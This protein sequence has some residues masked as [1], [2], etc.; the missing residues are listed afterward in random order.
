MNVEDYPFTR[1]TKRR[2]G[3][4]T[5]LQG[6]AEAHQRGFQD[7]YKGVNRNPYPKGGRRAAY[8]QAYARCD[9]MGEHNA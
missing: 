4:T 6:L 3:N 5:S 8:D 9:P 1:G 7:A 2:I